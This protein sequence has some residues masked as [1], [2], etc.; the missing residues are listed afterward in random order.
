MSA[1]Q[2][3]GKIGTE[4]RNILYTVTMGRDW[5]VKPIHLQMIYSNAKL[6]SNNQRR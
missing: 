6:T 1:Q 3:D 4:R 2:K 5:P